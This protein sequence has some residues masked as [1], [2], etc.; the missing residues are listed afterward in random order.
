[1][2]GILVSLVVLLVFC[3]GCLS[4]FI[5]G[6]GQTVMTPLSL[7]L[8]HWTEVKARAHNLSVEVKKGKWQTFC[9][10]EWPTF[11]VGWPLI[12]TFSLDVICAV[13]NIIVQREPGS[14]PDQQPYIV[15]WQDLAQDPP[16]WVQP[17][18]PPKSGS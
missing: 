11:G 16:S 5:D 1:M 6:M 12:G 17:W 2:L 9:S 8:D 4:Y 13:K 7:T 15:V 3:G 18:I 14:H 10:S